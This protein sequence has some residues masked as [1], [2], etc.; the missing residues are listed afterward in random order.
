MQC[1]KEIAELLTVGQ[2]DNKLWTKVD[3]ETNVCYQLL[4][5]GSRLRLCFLSSSST[6][7]VSQGYGSVYIHLCMCC[8][9]PVIQNSKLA[10]C[11]YIYSKTVLCVVACVLKVHLFIMLLTHRVFVVCVK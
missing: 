9:I 10:S 3:L 7:G 5:P 6:E 11:L 2:Y 4:F 8:I 1:T